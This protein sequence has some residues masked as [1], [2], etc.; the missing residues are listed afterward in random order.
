MFRLGRM[1]KKLLFAGSIVFGVTC[2]TYAEVQMSKLPV[3]VQRDMP[4]ANEYRR[5]PFYPDTVS[6][7]IGIATGF[8]A[9]LSPYAGIIAYSRIQ[10][11]KKIRSVVDLIEIDEDMLERV[12]IKIS[13]I[14]DQ[15]DR[16]R[17][18]ERCAWFFWTP[19]IST[20]RYITA[21][22]ELIKHINNMEQMLIDYIAQH[23]NEKAVDE[24]LNKANEIAENFIG[25]LDSAK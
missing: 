15:L 19:F 3:K 8:T 6:V 22:A 14:L 4:A 23:R 17:N 2:G 10:R 21:S 11:R 5:N 1:G 20:S 25:Q 18:Y 12:D 9:A 13:E 24:A 16:V 7:S